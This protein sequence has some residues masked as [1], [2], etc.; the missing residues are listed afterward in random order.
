MLN[1]NNT[2]LGN[3]TRSRTAFTLIAATFLIG[4]SVTRLRPNPGTIA[5]F[6]TTPASRPGVTG[7]MPMPRWALRAEAAFRH[8]LVLWQ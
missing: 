4:G 2:M 1:T 3:L 6:P 7:G 5:T 8:G